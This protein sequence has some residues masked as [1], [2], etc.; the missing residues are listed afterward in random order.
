MK[1]PQSLF[2]L[3][4][5]NLTV[6]LSPKVG[7]S[8][9]KWGREM[10]LGRFQHTVDS[11]GR[12]SIPVKFR[13][14]LASPNGASSEMMIISTDFDRC[15]VAYPIPEWRQIEEK[16]RKLPMMDRGVKDFLRFFYSWAVECPLDRQGRILIP[17]AL[18]EYANLYRDA[19]LIG[20]AN[21][22]EFWDL[23]R[24]KEREIQVSKQADRISETLA[25][26]GM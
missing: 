2:S 9:D 23:E 6:Y 21:K 12:V 25:N 17:P 26:L 4:N 24:W 19:I 18:R 11:K 14:A 1:P 15:L 10:F 22:I 16:I 20:M 13:E 8:G 3:T 7:S 5:Q